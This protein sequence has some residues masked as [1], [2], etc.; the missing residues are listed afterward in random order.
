MIIREVVGG[1][2]RQRRR[3]EREGGVADRQA[4]GWKV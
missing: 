2:G 1:A 3:R 4:D